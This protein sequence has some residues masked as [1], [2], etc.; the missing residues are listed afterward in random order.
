[1][2]DLK[3]YIKYFMLLWL[4]ISGL[5]Q[6][7]FALP[8]EAQEPVKRQFNQKQLEEY[9]QDRDFQYENVVPITN[10]IWDRIKY[11][12]SQFL[13]L[14]FSEKGAA[15]FIRYAILA[16]IILAV[17]VYLTG[18]QF[19]WF[20]GKDN[21]AKVGEISF[22]QDD[23]TRVDPET[24]ANQALQNGDLRL[25]IRYRYL[26]LLK[27]LNDKEYIEW[28]K[29]KTNLDYLSEIKP[30]HIKTQFKRHTLIFDYVW[31]G[32]FQVGED[33]FQAIHEGFNQLIYAIQNNN[34]QG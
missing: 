12:I 29:D 15:P 20:F 2:P 25:C 7:S 1:M 24:L 33:Q 16:A 9:R 11:Y 32:Q 3:G 21:K 13:K 27:T 30:P 4:L 28:H 22:V 6:S 19:Q 17:I 26:Q 23:I 34:E 18:G 14:I 5:S 10:T 8:K 31:Y